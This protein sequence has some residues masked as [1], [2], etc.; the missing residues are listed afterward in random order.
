M[1]ETNRGPYPGIDP[2]LVNDHLASL[3]IW[4]NDAA[5]RVYMAQLATAATKG[6]TEHRRT[7]EDDQCP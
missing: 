1:G 5:K 6:H 3:G 7:T 4:M 2:A